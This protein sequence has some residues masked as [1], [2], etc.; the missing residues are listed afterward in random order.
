[1]HPL[2]SD[3]ESEQVAAEGASQKSASQPPCE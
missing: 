3:R 1:M 2:E